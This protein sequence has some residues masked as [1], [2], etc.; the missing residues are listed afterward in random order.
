MIF[1]EED[2]GNSPYSRYDL[3]Q[4]YNKNHEYANTKKEEVKR[5]MYSDEY[6]NTKK[7]EGN[8][9]MH[10]DMMEDSSSEEKSDTPSEDQKRFL[11]L[12]KFC[13]TICRLL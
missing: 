2:Y 1:S 11:H 4:E 12:F 10:S 6:V 7:E 8:R 3:W 5:E 9:E 13:V